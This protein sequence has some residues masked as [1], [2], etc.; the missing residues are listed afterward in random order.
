M[1]KEKET[2][3]ADRVLD[4]SYDGIQEYDNR[5]PNWW[6]WTLW[7]SIVFGIG[8]WLLFHTY[9][10]YKNPVAQYEASMEGAAPSAD[11]EARGLSEADLVAMSS[12]AAVLAAGKEVYTQYCQVC[13]LPTGAGLVGPNLTD[14]Y[15]IHGGSAIAIH[16]TIVNG[17]VE[18]GMAAWGRQLGPDRVDAVTAYL[19]P[20]R[21]TNIE[22]GKAPQGDLFEL[23]AE[24]SMDAPT[25]SDAEAEA[26]ETTT[27]AETATE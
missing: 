10:V 23:P 5:L 21:G 14:D 18:K 16:E 2:Y 24:E 12:D 22:G 25:G 13:H 27:E 6:L 4:H 11:L 20:L 3:Q 26:V 1:S 19:L 8:Y 17:V 7:G 9:E 15:W